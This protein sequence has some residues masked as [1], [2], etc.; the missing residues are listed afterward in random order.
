MNQTVETVTQSFEYDDLYLFIGGE[1]IAAGHRETSPVVNPASGQIIGHVPH[2]TSEDLDRA[3]AIAQSSFAI[4]SKTPAYSR[5]R[6]LKRTAELIRE[7]A[8]HIER[9][10]TTEEGKALHEAEYEI[11]AAADYFEWFA[12]QGKR[13]YG[14]VVPARRPEVQ[15]L[16]KRQP[17]GPVA[18]FTPWNFPGIT[19]SRK[20]AAALAAGCSVII[21]AAEECPATALAIARALDDAGLPKGVVQMVFGVPTQISSHLIASPVIHKVT[22]PGS[23]PVG[24]LLAA[25]AAQGVKPI[26]LELGGHGPVLVFDDAD[27]DEAAALG[28]ANRFRG[29]GQVCISSTRF[30]IQRRSYAH[31]ADQFVAAT[32]ALSVGDGLDPATRVGPLANQRQLDKIDALVADAVQH[33]ARV[34]TGGKRIGQ[35][36]FFYAPTVLAD[37]PF[38]ARVMHEEPFGPIAI[39]RPFD[40]LEDGLAEANRLPY[41]LSAYA[42]TTNARTA[43]AVGDGLEAGM[44]GINHFNMINAELPFGGF[45]D[46]GYG[47]EGGEEGIEGYLTTKFIS[48]V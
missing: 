37:V 38:E 16:V 5:A 26:T 35:A 9:L 10:M 1:W 28:A 6:I 24:R 36:G 3:L 31:F 46:S 34:L 33:G 32:E 39:L 30:L 23:V 25:Q 45:K 4:W 7:R 48:Q 47:S 20:L 21:K 8:R 15:Q 12:E 18:A 27:L 19:P 44:I 40:T 17:I 29:T 22:F 42:F 2:A 13:A 43:V 14:R 41:A 11:A